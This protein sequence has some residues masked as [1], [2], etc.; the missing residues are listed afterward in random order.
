MTY[1]DTAADIINVSD[2]T[3]RVEELETM[4][5]DYTNDSVDN[6]EVTAGWAE[7]FPDESDELAELLA[8]LDDLRGNG[9]DHQWRGDWYPGYLIRDSYTE[10]Y[11]R[12]TAEDCGL[13]AEDAQWPAYCI[14]WEQAT[15]DFLMDYSTI[16]IE[17]V[18]YWYR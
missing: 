15:R 2:L 11:A 10:D 16:E 6:P 8:L 4:A 12:Q 5:D 3:D 7:A 13:I 18:T 1:I 9:G 17:D 14:D